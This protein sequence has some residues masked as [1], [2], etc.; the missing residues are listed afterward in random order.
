MLLRVQSG[1]NGRSCPCFC[2]ACQPPQSAWPS[3]YLDGQKKYK[4][5]Q[6]QLE[7]SNCVEKI[8][9]FIGHLFFYW[10]RYIY[11]F[12]FMFSTGTELKCAA[13]QQT[14]Y[15]VRECAHCKHCTRMAHCKHCRYCTRMEDCKYCNIVR[16]WS[17]VNIVDIVQ[18]W[19][20][21]KTSI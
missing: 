21:R 6:A 9:F 14:L 13:V 3:L 15:A 18:G 5:S 1:E 8:H 16:G 12:A 19:S 11:L 7:A 2:A 4:P 17:I 20:M 10:K